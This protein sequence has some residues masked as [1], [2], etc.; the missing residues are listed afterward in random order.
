MGQ[1]RAQHSVV[2][3][4]NQANGRGCGQGGA[5][6]D[7]RRHLN[8]RRGAALL[9]DR[10]M[11]VRSGEGFI[12]GTQR[13]F[14]VDDGSP[15]L[16]ALDL[17]RAVERLNALP[18]TGET[19]MPLRRAAL[20]AGSKAP[21]SSRTVNAIKSAVSAG[22]PS[23]LTRVGRQVHRQVFTPAGARS[24]AWPLNRGLTAPCGNSLPAAGFH[25]F[26][27]DHKGVNSRTRS[28]QRSDFGRRRLSPH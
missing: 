1:T 18:H 25:S 22:C 13:H 10:P 15:A 5:A 27:P 12:V 23:S 14:E 6:G 2:I 11:R 17:H 26:V 28:L 9:S 20:R 16:C 24:K 19:E 3:D 4:Q 21:P 7:E 8:A